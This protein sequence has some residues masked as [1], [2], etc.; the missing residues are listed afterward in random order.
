MKRKFVLGTAHRACDPTA[1]VA[2]LARAGFGAARAA[3]VRRWGGGKTNFALYYASEKAPIFVELA[4]LTPDR[5]L[6]QGEWELAELLVR[7]RARLLSLRSF[8][9]DRFYENADPA[10]V[11]VVVAFLTEENEGFAMQA[12]ESEA[13]S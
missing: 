6:C 11:D 8:A 4:E 12:P 2:A 5:D 7:E 13:A 10:A 1:L 9:E 3:D